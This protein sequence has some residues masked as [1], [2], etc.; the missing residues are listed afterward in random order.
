MKYV[1]KKEVVFIVYCEYDSGENDYI[2]LHY[3]REEAEEHAANLNNIV[4]TAKQPTKL[5]FKNQIS[6]SYLFNR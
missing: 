3:D 2:Q 6:I 4:K 1:V 5:Y